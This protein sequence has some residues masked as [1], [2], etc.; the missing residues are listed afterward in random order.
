M[1]YGCKFWSRLR[2]VCHDRYIIECC[3]AAAIQLASDGGAG[4]FLAV[5]TGLMAGAKPGSSGGSATHVYARG[6]WEAPLLS[7]PA[8]SSPSLA[9]AFCPLLF[10]LRPSLPGDAAASPP[11]TA[12]AGATTAAAV[13]TGT[14]ETPLVGEVSAVKAAICPSCCRCLCRLTFV[15]GSLDE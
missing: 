13:D 5:P 15:E 6:H 3:D 9:V 1:V 8:P 7:L 12:T 4:S 11:V 14:G 10:A 2:W